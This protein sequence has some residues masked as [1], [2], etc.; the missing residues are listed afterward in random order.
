[1]NN[2]PPD[3]SHLPQS[4]QQFIKEHYISINGVY[5]FTSSELNQLIKSILELQK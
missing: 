3:L 1:M 5:A 4:I 2:N